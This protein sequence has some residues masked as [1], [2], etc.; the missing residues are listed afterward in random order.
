M[1]DLSVEN[2]AGQPKTVGLTH[3]TRYEK[4]ILEIKGFLRKMIKQNIAKSDLKNQ[5]SAA[6][7]NTMNK[8][9][10]LIDENKFW[11]KIFELALFLIECG[12]SVEIEN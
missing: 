11:S 9:I 1:A 10:N 7:F 8:Y 3:L 12:V 6:I 4:D 5:L 2:Q